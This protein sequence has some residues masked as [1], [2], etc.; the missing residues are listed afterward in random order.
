ME[1]ELDTLYRQRKDGK[2]QVC[3]IKVYQETD[4]KPASITTTHGIEDAKQQIDINLVFSG[5]NLGKANATTAWQQAL[6]EAQSKWNEKRD[7][8]YHV[9]K[10]QLAD[11]DFLPMLAYEY[12]ERIP[13]V[14][15]EMKKENRDTLTIHIQPKL[16]GVRASVYIVDGKPQMFSRKGKNISVSAPHILQHFV[17]MSPDIII[18]GELYSQ[19]GNIQAIA[20]AANKKTYEEDRHGKLCFVIFDAYRKDDP[21]LFFDERFNGLAKIEH[22]DIVFPIDRVDFSQGLCKTIRVS[23]QEELDTH[24]LQAHREATEAGFEGIMVRVNHYPYMK[25]KRTI[26]LLKYKQFHDAEYEIVDITTPSSGRTAGAAIFVCKTSNN[27]QFNCDSIGTLQERRSLYGNRANLIGK[28]LTV[29]YQDL[30]DDAVPRF[31]KA[32]VVRDYE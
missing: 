21:G 23:T 14:F 11:D 4:E 24:V 7:S 27:I 12:E 15:R 31:P 26:G 22:D 32:I 1:Q 30:T 6:S 25:Q 2:W 29:Q 5:K 18:D 13:S 19:H 20:G 16:D 8:G 17:N 3:K 9:N 28:M 10:I